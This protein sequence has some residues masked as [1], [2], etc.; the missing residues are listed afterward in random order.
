MSIDSLTMLRNAATTLATIAAR[1]KE[2]PLGVSTTLALDPASGHSLG[3]Q[4]AD[5]LSH[6]P[7]S[8]NFHRVSLL[9]QISMTSSFGCL[10]YSA[11]PGNASLGSESKYSDERGHVHY[12]QNNATMKMVQA[13]V[14]SSWPLAV[15]DTVS[16]H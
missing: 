7:D 16:C 4:C 13:S 10:S 8:A 14:D 6:C 11:N 3:T 9:T 15:P 5:A 2:L 1:I 12:A